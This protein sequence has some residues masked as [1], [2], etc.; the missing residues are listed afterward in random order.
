MQGTR[1]DLNRPPLYPGYPIIYDMDDADFLLPHLAG[2]GERAVREVTVVIAG[3]RYIEDWCL[4]AG[5]GQA[6][7]VWTGESISVRPRM[8]QADR[9]PVVA[10][11]QT[12]PIA[13]TREASLVRGAMC[14]GGTSW[15]YAQIIR[16][17]SGG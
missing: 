17:P 13:Y 3:L 4:N 6:R 16:L 11:A 7:L 12:R 1:H 10:W 8:P 2:P 5:A 14:C 9:S 15:Y